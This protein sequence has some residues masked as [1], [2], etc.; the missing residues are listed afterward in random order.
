MNGGRA[1]EGRGLRG[2]GEVAEADVAGPAAPAAADP[3]P[4]PAAPATA[5]PATQ[6][7]QQPIALA[8]A[9]PTPQPPPHPLNQK[10]PARKE[11]NHHLFN[12]IQRI[13]MNRT[14]PH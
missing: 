3:K 10:V 5:D 2:G 9:D 1:G 13:G 7:R 4:Q 14:K 12:R 6:P 11:G 8:A